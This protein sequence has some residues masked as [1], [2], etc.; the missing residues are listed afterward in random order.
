MSTISVWVDVDLDDVLDDIS[1][2]DLIEELR[3]R[4]DYDPE[5]DATGLRFV[6]DCLMR[7]DLNGGLA[8]LDAILFPRFATEMEAKHAYDKAKVQQINGGPQ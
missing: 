2:K 7:G 4:D 5:P 3:S 1:T 8:A 6:R